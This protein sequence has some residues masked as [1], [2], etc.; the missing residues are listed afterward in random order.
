MKYKVR[1]NSNLEIL[2]GGHAFW[3]GSK[4]IVRIGVSGATVIVKQK[5]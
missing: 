4:K 3:N 5:I 1:L 2:A